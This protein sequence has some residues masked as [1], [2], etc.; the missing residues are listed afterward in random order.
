MLNHITLMGRLVKDPETRY[1]KAND[2]V[3]SFTIAVDRDFQKDQTDFISCVAWRKTGEF[4]GKYF[5]KGSMIALTGSLQSR[6]WTDKEGNKRISWEVNV[7]H[8]Y[9]A[10]QKRSEFQQPAF[11]EVDDESTGELPF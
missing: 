6:S 11:V 3:A 8:A 9:F 10:E 2:P 5:R 7:D 1:T 4:I